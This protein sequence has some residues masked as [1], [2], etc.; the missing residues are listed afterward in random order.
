MTN[1]EQLTA[2]QA[3]APIEEEVVLN[4]REV[5]NV[6]QSRQNAY[7]YY[8]LQR[9]TLLENWRF[10]W[11]KHPELGLGQWP[12]DVVAWMLSQKRHLVQHNF[13]QVI[14]DTLA[15]GLAQQPF[16]PDFIPV[17]EEIT[18]L[19][20]GIQK[21]SYSDK[22]IM[23]WGHTDFETIRDGMVGGESAV[24][25][26]ISR[27][28]DKLGNIGF[29]HCLPGT[30]YPDP[31]WKTMVSSDCKVCWVDTWHTARNLIAK[32]PKKAGLIKW[33][34]LTSKNVEEYAQPTG[35]TPYIG[36]G[37]DNLGSTH[38]LTQEYRIISKAV[39]EEWVK[40]PDIGDVLIPDMP[41]NDKPVWLNDNYPGWDPLSVE[42]REVQKSLCVVRSTCP[43]IAPSEFL[44][45]GLCEIQIGRLPFIFWSPNRANGE[46]GCPMDLIKDAQTAIN[47]WMSLAENKLQTEGGGG[48]GLA[49]PSKFVSR[50]GEG[51]YNDFMK[52]KNTPG[53]L[54]EV[55]PGALEG[56][57]AAVYQPVAKSAFPAEVLQMIQLLI[58]TFLPHISKV[59]STTRGMAEFSGE[60][61]RLFEVMKIQSDQQVYTI[62]QS[63]RLFKNEVYEAYFMLATD[64]YSNN[65]VE[66]TFTYNRG[67]SSVTLNKQVTLSD[68]SIGII[69]DVSRLKAIRHKVIISETQF[70][71]SQKIA[72]M[73]KL[74]RFI[75][76]VG[77]SSPLIAKYFVNKAAELTTDFN[78]DDKE[79]IGVLG[80]AEIDRDLQLTLM[81]KVEAELRT[82]KA[83]L[84][85]MQMPT[86]QEAEEQIRL[87]KE[88]EEKARIEAA[89]QPSVPQQVQSQNMQVQA[90]MQAQGALAQGNSNIPNAPQGE[91]VG[92]TA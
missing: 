76:S 57:G 44:E 65:R 51:G 47:Y 71:P 70:S 81:Q 6:E 54:F 21:A 26:Y 39:K 40:V 4:P 68:G 49:D 19:Q 28:Y 75:K 84:E 67:R 90:P 66:R 7:D 42:I 43:T 83:M 1:N 56:G 72:N 60:S 85:L 88:A 35:P 38:R 12:K 36:Q 87:K 82:R 46:T 61:G 91:E 17:S 14:I 31:N 25:I 13:C 23:N 5:F 77:G 8:R 55:K 9:E 73:E 41:S 3:S 58:G 50:D 45:N 20:H 74:S 2:P 78:D 53:K 27:E 52:N 29:K 24:K 30:V 86:E 15:G 10:Y 92:A 69:N 32:Y 89:N 11:A 63:W 62:N 37:A 64:T 34:L 22:E 80:D 48:A 79:A 16:D 59:N 33:A 18:S